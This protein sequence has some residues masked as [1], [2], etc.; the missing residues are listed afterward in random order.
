MNNDDVAFTEDDVLVYKKLQIDLDEIHPV[1]VQMQG[2]LYDVADGVAN[3][4][5]FDGIFYTEDITGKNPRT[6]CAGPRGGIFYDED[7]SGNSVYCH[8]CY[9]DTRRGSDTDNDTEIYK[10]KVFTATD[11]VDFIKYLCTDCAEG[12]A[13]ALEDYINNNADELLG[14]AL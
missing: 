4:G 8:A 2:V 9:T 5:G 10:V 12:F 3:D 11:D 6:R 7:V 13:D 1:V 14:D